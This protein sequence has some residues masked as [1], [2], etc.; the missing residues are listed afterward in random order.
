MYVIQHRNPHRQL[1]GVGWQAAFLTCVVP[2]LI[3]DG[4]KLWLAVTLSKK[5]RPHMKV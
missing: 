3:P 2:Y 1:Y 5:L 4:L